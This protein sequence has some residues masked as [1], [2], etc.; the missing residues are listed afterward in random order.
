MSFSFGII[1]LPNVGKSTL[2]NALSSA[3]AEASNYP[4]CT[5]D[6]N[7]GVV[8]VPDERL[9]K[10]QKEA[11]SAKA[12]P[13]IIEFH[14]I[15]GLVKGAS[16]G[17]GLGNQ[18]LGHI[19][20]V[21]AI[22]HVVRCFPDPNV[23]HVSGKVDP[24]ADIEI[25]QAEL[26]LADLATVEKQLERAKTAAKGGDKKILRE[27]EELEKL[28]DGLEKGIGYGGWGLDLLTS[29]PVLYLAN[30]DESGNKDQVAIIEEI[31]KKENTKV[32]AVCAKLEAEVKELSSDEAKEFLKEIGSAESGVRKFIKASYKLLDL[33]TFFTANKKE[34]RAWTL[35][36]GLT[37]Y[38]AA[39]KVH[40]DMQRGF[41]SAEVAGN[42][43][44]VG[45][46]YIVQDG[47][48]LLFRF[49]V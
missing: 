29:K 26:A 30:V 27:V 48:L 16:K 28:K 17:E 9:E 21:D 39:G 38:D 15:A 44:T 34:C 12:V 25:I 24:K 18:F 31:A 32:V 3:H 4:F 13:T 14:D 47:D 2:F 6:P 33:I 36:R 45:R 5:I 7:V 8:E 22:I 20:N 11:G 1:G 37:A 43:K 46:D 35:K 19:R 10:I 49:N 40:T 41:I 42:P 23:I